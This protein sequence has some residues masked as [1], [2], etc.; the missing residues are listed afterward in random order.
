[1]IHSSGIRLEAIRRERND[2]TERKNYI[3]EDGLN[4]YIERYKLRKSRKNANS[5]SKQN[6]KRRN[7]V[8]EKKNKNK[9][10][11]IEIKEVGKEREK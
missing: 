2:K 11:I 4:K 5:H 1:M 10:D 8:N 6:F 7:A 9:K 3:R